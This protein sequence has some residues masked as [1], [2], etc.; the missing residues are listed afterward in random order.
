MYKKRILLLETFIW[1]GV[2]AGLLHMG[3]GYLDD[4]FHQGK[5]YSFEFND[6]DSVIV[7]SPVKLMGTN[8]GN[9]TTVKSV[10]NKA[11]IS[12]RI[13]DDKIIIPPYSSISVQFTG[14][15][16]SRSIEIT[17]QDIQKNEITNPLN[18]KSSEQTTHVEQN[19]FRVIEPIR[20]GQIFDLQKDVSLSVL[21]L[22][23]NILKTFGAG[24]LE[25]LKNNIVQSKVVT[26][27]ITKTLNNSQN[28]I[29]NINS[30]KIIIVKN[31]KSNL[32]YSNNN[33]ELFQNELNKASTLQNIYILSDYSNIYSK[34]VNDWHEKYLKKIIDSSYDA[35]VISSKWS[36][37]KTLNSNAINRN[38]CVIDSSFNKIEKSAKI[39][40]KSFSK[41]K[42][43]NVNKNLNCINLFLQNLKDKL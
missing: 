9:V 6:A 25:K 5:I 18:V 42:I 14:L 34:S 31:T 24:G 37:E 21:D 40:K 39:I 41:D 8:V 23:T 26:K 7:G 36:Q 15:A 35:K 28:Q 12:V 33:L 30:Q 1:V 13:N 3:I 19:N 29:A 20:V 4:K 27:N 32:S 2:L 22:S 43:N 16:G 11:L 17:P 10:G 38:F